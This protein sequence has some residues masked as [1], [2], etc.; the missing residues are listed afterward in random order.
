MGTGFNNVAKFGWVYLV[1]VLGLSVGTGCVREHSAVTGK[2]KAY[3]FSWNQEMQLG[4]QSDEQIVRQFGLYDDPKVQAYV[5]EIGQSILAHS[6]LRD[7][8]APE[9]YRNTPFTFRVLNSPVVNAFA[10]PGGYIYVTRGL[11]AHLENEAQLAVVL[12]HEI[13]H[14]AARH[15]AQQALRAQWGQIG[16]VAAGILGQSVL[17]PAGGDL[18]QAGGQAFQLLL[19]KYGREAERE[20]DLLGVKYAAARG[21]DVIYASRFFDSLHRISQREGVTL[22]S[23]Q[24]T[25]PDPGEREQ[26]IVNLARQYDVPNAIKRVGR[27]EFLQAIEGMPVGDD[28]REGFVRNGVFY[29]PE[30]AFQFRVPEGWKMKN[31]RAAV[32]LR[33]SR[34]GAIMALELVSARSAREAAAKFSQTPGIELIQSDRGR[35][36]DLNAIVIL[37]QGKTQQGQVGVL[38]HFIEHGGKVYSFLGLTAPQ[39]LTTYAREFSQIASTFSPL[40]DPSV[41]EVQ[42]ARIQLVRAP[43]QTTLRDLLKGELPPG[44]EAEQV[45]ILNQIELDDPLEKGRL[46][47]LPDQ[48]EFRRGESGRVSS[49]R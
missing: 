7:K 43:R 25:H 11:L 15:S 28:P 18:F 6:D 46:I 31:E 19:T 48:S 13:A 41:K 26:T 16:L 40:R 14:V 47:K 17:G 8:D 9:M 35:V 2:N 32:L 12:G 10:L 30:L 49:Y 24:S 21:Y 36:G 39:N 37:A 5:E 4:K 23:W 38:N 27:D 29:H 42:P 33:D 20:S 1:A 44:L 34:G 45:A 3:A 22:P